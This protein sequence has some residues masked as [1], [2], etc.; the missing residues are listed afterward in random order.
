MTQKWRRTCKRARTS[1]VSPQRTSSA[2]AWRVTVTIRSAACPPSK[3]RTRRR[4]RHCDSTPSKNF[5][6]RKVCGASLMTSNKMRGSFNLKINH[7][8]RLV[9]KM[10]A[11]HSLCQ[12]EKAFTNLFNKRS[13]CR[14][15][16]SIEASI[17]AKA[18]WEIECT[19][20]VTSQKRWPKICHRKNYRQFSHWSPILNLRGIWSLKTTRNSI[21]QVG[22][23]TSRRR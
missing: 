14:M 7:S 6:Q 4:P 2:I 19:S 9:W 22:T 23:V 10:L 1:F 12:V 11:N 18:S 15:D 3:R 20:T 8:V 13:I 16:S 5:R 21:M 17:V